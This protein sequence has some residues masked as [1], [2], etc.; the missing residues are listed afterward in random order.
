MTVQEKNKSQPDLIN[1]FK[2]LP[3]YNRYT[4]KPKIKCLKNIDLLS[5]LPFYEE[6]NVIKTDHAFKGYAMSYKVELVEKKDSLVQLEASKSSIKDL[7]NNLLDETKGFKYQIT[8]KAE[9]KKYKV[10]KIEF[11]LVHF[12]STTKTV[13]NH[14]FDLERSF[15]EI[16][17]RIGNWINERSG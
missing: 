14:K 6:L 5:E 15:Q 16:L 17:Y 1:Y 8:F 7:F 13:I 9:L 3:F 4:E 2:E 10:S 12:S 11:A